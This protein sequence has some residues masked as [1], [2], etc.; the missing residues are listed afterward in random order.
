MWPCTF[1]CS[2]LS[3][4]WS[5][6]FMVLKKLI[7]LWSVWHDQSVWHGL[8]TISPCYWMTVESWIKRIL[9]RHLAHFW[10][11][12]SWSN[13]GFKNMEYS[14]MWIF[15]TWFWPLKIRSNRLSLQGWAGLWL[16]YLLGDLRLSDMYLWF[17][18]KYKLSPCITL[19][20]QTELITRYLTRLGWFVFLNVIYK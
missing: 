12:P 4:W 17:L 2:S 11:N 5:M 9:L 1:F 13:S 8:I 18:R 16:F 15:G 3:K 19:I 7:Y 6:C 14:D 10:A 20:S